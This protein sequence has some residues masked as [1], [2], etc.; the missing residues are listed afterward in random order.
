MRSW[1]RTGGD[2]V[3]VV[4]DVVAGDYVAQNLRAVRVGGTIVQV[5]V[6]GSATATVPVGLLLSRRVHWVGTVLRGRPVEE[7]I[8]VSRRCEHDLVPLFESGAL[9]PVIDRRFPLDD[10]AAAHEYVASNANVGKVLLT[11]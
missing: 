4:L 7:K 8:A 10:V 11:L 6:M 9:R 3:D 5:G 1:P 2:G